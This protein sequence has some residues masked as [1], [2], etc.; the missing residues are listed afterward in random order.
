M[1]LTRASSLDPTKVT[2]QL[3]HGR[4]G[5]APDSGPIEGTVAGDMFRFQSVR[6]K[7][8]GELRVWRRDDW[9][10]HGAVWRDDDHPGSASRRRLRLDGQPGA[11]ERRRNDA[12]RLPR[13]DGGGPYC[14]ADPWSYAF[15]VL[16]GVG[17]L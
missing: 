2:G 3:T 15:V 13:R 16:L 1:L 7:T 6:G 14:L 12:F 9:E 4:S 17:G 10:R 5:I 8:S 11:D